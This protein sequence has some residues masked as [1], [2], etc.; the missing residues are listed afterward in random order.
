[1]RLS[2]LLLS[3]GFAALL[4]PVSLSGQEVVPA[5]RQAVLAAVDSFFAAMSRR[6]TAASRAILLPGAMFYAVA[7]G[8][9]PGS[10]P[11]T[12][13]IRSIGGRTAALRERI[14]NPR[15]EVHGPIAEVWTRYDF[16][17]DGKFSHC[18]ID[19]FSLMLTPSGWTIAAATYTVE[20]TGC[21]ESPLGPLPN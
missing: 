6:D 19:D 17:V 3:F 9:A 18:G 10:T 7:P 16:H 12:A 8:R 2:R 1:M 5:E 4:G 11:D 15:V 14:W 21:P 20:R 13:Y